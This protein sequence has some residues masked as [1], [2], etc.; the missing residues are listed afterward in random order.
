MSDQRLSL[1]SEFPT[2]DDAAWRAVVD[3]ALKGA[4][5]DKKLKTKTR[6]GFALD[7]LYTRDGAPVSD[8]GLPG[9]FPYLRGNIAAASSD[10]GWDVR[11]A[12]STPS[13]ATANAV[14]LEELERGAVSITLVM[15]AVIQTLDPEH[16]AEA[17]AG[18]IAAYTLADFER[19]LEGVYL[20][21]APIAVNAGAGALP[22]AAAVL[23]LAQQRGLDLS[24]LQL[25]VNADPIGTLAKTGRL[26]WPAAAAVT[27]TAKFAAS[28]SSLAPSA[29]A[30]AVDTAPYYES[31]ASE[32]QDLATAMATGVA[33]LRALTEAGLS[34]EQAAAT[35][36]FNYRLGSD[37]FA[38]IAK[39]R[40]HRLLWSRVLDACGAPVAAGASALHAAT[41]ERII[42]RRDPW[43][44]M[45]RGTVTSLAAGLGGANSVSCLAFDAGLGVPASLG[46]RIARNTQLLAIEESNVGKVLDPAGGSWFIEKL[47]R[48][49]AEAAWPIFQEIEAQGGMLKSLETGHIQS[50]IAKVRASTA[51]DL[52]KRK[53]PI[54]GVSEFPDIG[55]EAVINTEIDMVADKQSAKDRLAALPKDAVT[56]P[57]LAAMMTALIQGASIPQIAA[58]FQKQPENI[59]PLSPFR[60]A[61]AFEELR[62]IS[63]M[64]KGERGA[65]PQIFLANLGTVAQHTARATYA[66][67]YF[68]AGGIEAIPTPGFATAPDVVAAFEDSGAELAV[69]CGTDAQYADM[70]AEVAEELKEAGCN[71]VFLVGRPGDLEDSLTLAGVDGFIFLGSDVLDTC[72]TILTHLGVLEQ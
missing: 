45:L 35:I 72:R 23:A 48:D 25:A 30:I 15:D 5:F 13:P 26:P 18:G 20:E 54:T 37:F 7:P 70:G 51:T 56:A 27:E 62:D 6:D 44:N 4:D 1:A 60:F 66:K 19:L 46:R 17:G 49:L 31:G 65:R 61:A 64:V 3:K 53:Q 36:A 16:G 42:T 41:A 69:I 34:L 8:G 57:D 43:V 9:T 40:A 68:E 58:G 33:Y 47:T 11:Q 10:G 12:V 32:A 2:P 67:N 52:A 55:E 59:Q 63:D 22:T 71:K 39:L 50:L 29:T 14:A 21:F 24:K 38:G 28:L